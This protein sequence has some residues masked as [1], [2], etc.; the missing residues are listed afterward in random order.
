MFQLWKILQR[1]KL[2]PPS[3]PKSRIKE[4]YTPPLPQSKNV[5]TLQIWLRAEEGRKKKKEKNTHQG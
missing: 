5:S 3:P 1:Y 4:I 2:H